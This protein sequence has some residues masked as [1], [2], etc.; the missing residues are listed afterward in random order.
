M[1][2]AEHSANLP[3]PLIARPNASASPTHLTLTTR[4][5]ALSATRFAMLGPSG[6]TGW[7]KREMAGA[8][9]RRALW[10]PE[11][12]HYEYLLARP[13][14]ADLG[15][16]LVEAMTA[17]ETEFPPLQGVLPRDF[18]IFERDVLEDL[19]RIF[20]REALRAAAPDAGHSPFAGLPVT[21]RPLPDW[22]SRRATGE[23][24]PPRDR[25]MS[26]AVTRAETAWQSS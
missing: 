11:K 24:W 2:T 12:A 18:T 26:G 9:N 5:A 23:R 3:A 6:Y 1:A 15:Q 7:M 16:A 17:I 13:K 10:L 20:N 22:G 4:F 19:L 25:I 14:D 21:G 8:T